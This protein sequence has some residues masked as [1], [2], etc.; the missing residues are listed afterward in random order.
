M[1]TDTWPTT[2]SMPQ[3]FMYRGYAQRRQS[4]IIRSSMGYG[5]AKV[6]R[7]TTA[8]I[9]VVN[10]S[11]ILTDAQKSDL[12]TFYETTLTDGS[13]AFN[14]PNNPLDDT[15]VEMRFTAPIQW[16][17]QGPNAWMAVMNLEILP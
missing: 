9:E 17:K 2:N 5:P 6:R 10:A 8:A 16:S 15:T 7:R 1:A 3:T 11:L 14:H 13:E 12:V 4:N